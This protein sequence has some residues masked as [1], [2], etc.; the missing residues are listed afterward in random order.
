MEQA[1][2]VIIGSGPAGYTAALYNSRAQLKPVVFA[3]EKSGGQL[4]WTTDVENFPGFP[5]GKPGP[6]LMLAI[7]EQAKK[8]GADIRDQ[9]VTAVD[10]S[11]Q[12]FKIWTTV[13]EGS[14]GEDF[15]KKSTTELKEAQVKIRQTEPS[16][17]AQAVIVTTGAVSRMLGIPGEEKFLGRGLSTCAVCDAAFY[18][19]KVT[20]VAGGGDSAMEEVLALTKFA[21][22][23][24]IVHRRDELRA[25][26]IMQDRV[27]NHQKVEVMYNTQVLEVMGDQ[28][29]NKIKIS[30][31]GKEQELSV[32]GLFLAIGHKPVTSIFADQIN[33]DEQ[34]YIVTRQSATKKGVIAAGEA[35]E[36][37]ELLPFPTMTSVEGVFAAGDV[38]DVRYRQAITAAGQGCSAALDAERWLEQQ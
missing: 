15:E 30:Q 36:D 32:D 23:V 4:M 10:F 7:R 27:L 29:V 33:L 11:Q 35:I 26:K 1:K 5:E 21:K 20:V 6:E 37:K 3:G 14:V 24:I 2:V 17:T 25:S 31:D 9:Y 28:V 19:D 8:F 18:R 12:P 22:K 38:V 13:P 16:L 34:K